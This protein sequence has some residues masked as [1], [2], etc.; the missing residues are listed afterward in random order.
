MTTSRLPRR[1]IVGGVLAAS[2]LG[3]GLTLAMAQD[4]APAGACPATY[5]DPAG[6]SGLLDPATN[7]AVG[8]DDLDLV[9]VTHSVDGGVFSTAFKVVKLNPEGPN[10]AFGDRYVAS[11]TVAK[12]AVTVT[13]ERDF[14]GFG[15]IKGSAT[16]AGTAVTF[17]VKVAQDLKAN[18]ISAL[19]AAADLEK[20]VGAPLAGEKF[21]A[22]SAV[23]R[24]IYP[25]NAAS[26]VGVL[27]DDAE[28]P[29]TAAYAFGAGCGGASA[30]PAPSASASPSPS[31][32][33]AGS[34]PAAGG[35][36]LKD[37]PTPGCATFKDPKGDASY[38][39][40]P[41]DPDLDMTEVAMRTTADAFVTYIKVDKLAGKP[42]LTDGHR[43]YSE[44]TFNK[45]VFSIAVSQFNSYGG[46]LRPAAA[47]SGQ[48]G[49][50]S[51][52]SVDSEGTGGDPGFTDTKVTSSFDVK[53]NTVV[54]SVPL[55]AIEKYGKA[56]V[57]GA[58][59][60][61]V[62]TRAGY[63][64]GV[65]IFTADTVKPAKPAEDVY[66]VGDST[67]FA[68]P[69]P[70][71]ANVGATKAQYGDTAAVAAKL[72]DP[73]GAPV[74]G[75]AVTFTLGASKATGTTGADG[76]AKASLLVKELAGKRT[77]TI[78]AEG[79]TAAVDFTV[80][81]EKTVLKAANNKGTVTATLTDDDKTPLAGQVLT[82]TLGSK[83]ATA[84]TDA[85]GVAKV[86]GFPAGNVKVTYAGASGMYTAASATSTSSN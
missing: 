75:K 22:M 1:A 15:S 80:L 41:N 60:S 16:V 74:A 18:T 17:P 28:A 33:P 39:N 63:D 62:Q 53:T 50:M 42:S 23:A 69:T 81:L 20:A 86:S 32:A 30:A 47:Q 37:R 61:A 2:L 78:A 13:A 57:A 84:K 55:A 46:Q 5:T 38:N 68:P 29:A 54:L 83:K 31:A 56:P 58:T 4:A 27:W 45:H 3:G 70:P 24:A 82:F 10:A 14:S 67:C 36:P 52:M 51:V 72:V 49:P 8:D 35:D 85:R 76:I 21:S 59:F 40:T 65:L 66:V 44:F 25:S 43:F 64:S 48:V 12:K 11:F 71:L 77:L 34:A 6:D 19:M 7:P 26:S 9:A 79:T 73:A